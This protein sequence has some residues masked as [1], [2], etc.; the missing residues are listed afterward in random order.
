MIHDTRVPVILT[1]ASSNVV[2]ARIS[3]LAPGF[4]AL[5]DE[6]DQDWFQLFS[7]LFAYFGVVVLLF[8][9]WQR[10]WRKLLGEK[11]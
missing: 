2:F 8:I 11:S 5:A 1:G 3:L 4:I 9:G 6:N 7:V 10:E